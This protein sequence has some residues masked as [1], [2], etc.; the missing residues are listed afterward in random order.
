MMLS[1]SEVAVALA[2][3]E[4]IPLEEAQIRVAAAR[5]AARREAPSK[6]SRYLADVSP[7]AIALANEKGISVA[8]AQ[9]HVDQ[10]R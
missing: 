1:L 5:K 8:E 10:I 2:K 3:Q 6:D 4:N 7:A 9:R